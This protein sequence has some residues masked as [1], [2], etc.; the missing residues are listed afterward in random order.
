MPLDDPPQPRHHGRAPDPGGERG[1]RQL[2]LNPLPFVM[3]TLWLANTTSLLLPVSNLTNLHA[4]QRFSA[5]RLGPPGYISLAL[6]PAL[7]AVVATVGVLTVI[8]LRD[9]RGRYTLEAHPSPH[10]RVLLIGAGSVCVALGPAFASGITP[11][12]PASTAALVLIGLVLVRNRTLCAQSRSPGSSCSGSSRCSWLWTSRPG[13]RPA[14]RSR[15]LGRKRHG[16]F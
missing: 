2:R 3:T 16:D 14:R 6:W 8:H 1:C 4:P 12:S 11:A 5:L 13:I 7:A 10:D 15:Q 9:L